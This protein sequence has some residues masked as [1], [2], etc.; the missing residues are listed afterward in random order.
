MVMCMGLYRESTWDPGG[1]Y[2]G[3]D[4]SKVAEREKE[5]HWNCFLT[6]FFLASKSQAPIFFNYMST[7]PKKENPFLVWLKKK[8]WAKLKWFGKNKLV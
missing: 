2:K 5:T 1:E 8:K 4:K 3:K 7:P 6:K